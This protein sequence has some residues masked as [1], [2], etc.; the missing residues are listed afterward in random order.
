MRYNI[1]MN[2]DEIF[3]YVSELEGSRIDYPFEED[4]QTACFRHVENK[5]WFGL[6]LAVPKRFWGEGEGVD[7]CLNLKCPTD[8]AVILSKTYRG[9]TAAYHMNK[10]H[11]ITV[12]VSSD[13]PESEIKQ[14]ISLSYACTLQSA[15]RKL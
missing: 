7:F 5:K 12:R 3:F 2:R 6:W 9:I 15:K 11:W 4:F 8:L 13:V 1:A 14:L 10:N